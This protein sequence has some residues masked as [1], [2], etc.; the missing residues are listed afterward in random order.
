MIGRLEKLMPAQR[1][2]KMD[3]SFLTASPVKIG[4]PGSGGTGFFFQLGP[5]S[6]LVTAGHVLA[7]DSTA[8]FG[9]PQQSEIRADP[10]KISYYLRASEDIRNLTRHTLDLSNDDLTWGFDPAG[11][12]VVIIELDQEISTV[13][14][15]ITD[16]REPNEHPYGTLAYREFDFLGSNQLRTDRVYNLGYPGKLSDRETKFPIRRNAL[17]SSP[18]NF[19]YEGADR[20]LTDARMDPGTSGAPVLVKPSQVQRPTGE[21]LRQSSGAPVL[22]GIHSGN[23]PHETATE[24]DEDSMRE[25]SYSDLNETWRPEAIVRAIRAA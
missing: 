7:N 12:D 3:L 18:I 5:T 23:F 9:Q 21:S 2:Y 15:F 22:L 20:F 11:S 13:A 14:E 10:P 8:I 24:T 6:Y 19:E 16:D 17:I 1:G 4:E 25:Y